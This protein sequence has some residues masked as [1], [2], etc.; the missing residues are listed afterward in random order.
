MFLLFRDGMGAIGESLLV[1]LRDRRRFPKPWRIEETST[2]FIVRDK[3]GEGLA[4]LYFADHKGRGV[5]LHT[6]CEA[7]SIAAK[8]A[9]MVQ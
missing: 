2:S 8:I 6:R 1:R 5:N 3:D 4:Y 7:Q 9:K